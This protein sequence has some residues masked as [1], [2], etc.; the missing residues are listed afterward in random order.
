MKAVLRL[1]EPVADANLDTRRLRLTLQ[2]PPDDFREPGWEAPTA[3]EGSLALCG[4]SMVVL[5][6]RPLA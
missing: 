5:R 3:Q 4:R 6:T 2:D 1:V